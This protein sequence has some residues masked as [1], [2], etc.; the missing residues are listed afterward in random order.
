MLLAPGGPLGC[1]AVLV[2]RG[3]VGGVPNLMGK[4]FFP[5]NLWLCWAS[6]VAQVGKRLPAMWFD[7]W[8]RK[9]P[10]RR[11][12]NP[13]QYS[14]LENSIDGE[15]VGCSPWGHK[16]LDMT[17]RLHFLAFFLFLGCLELP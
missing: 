14:C 12:C 16:E 7:P 10:R 17:E 13:L 1:A 9:I 11:Q 5:L 3:L 8:V 4:D 2:C 6:P 15:L